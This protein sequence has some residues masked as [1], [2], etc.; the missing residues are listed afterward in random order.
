MA[1]MLAEVDRVLRSVTWKRVEPEPDGPLLV[2]FTG[3]D[4]KEEWAFTVVEALAGEKP[5][6]GERGR[7][8]TFDAVAVHEPSGTILRLTP[9]LAE[10]ALHMAKG[11]LR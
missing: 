4:P 5:A 8:A 11:N 6:P 2:T 3:T 7:I 10:R 9:V 1:Q